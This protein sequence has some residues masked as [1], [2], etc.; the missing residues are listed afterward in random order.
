[1]LWSV[2]SISNEILVIQGFTT[3][4]WCLM[5]KKQGPWGRFCSQILPWKLAACTSV[6]LS[7][8][9]VAVQLIWTLNLRTLFKLVYRLL[10]NSAEKEADSSSSH[11]ERGCQAAEVAETTSIQKL[12][13]SN[14]ITARPRAETA[15]FAAL[16]L[17]TVPSGY[18]DRATSPHLSHKDPSTARMLL[19]EGRGSRATQPQQ[20]GYHYLRLSLDRNLQDFSRISSGFHMAYRTTHLHT[21][22]W[23]CQVFKTTTAPNNPLLFATASLA[24]PQ[25]RRK[26]GRGLSQA[27]ESHWGKCWQQFSEPIYAISHQFVFLQQQSWAA[28]GWDEGRRTAVIEGKWKGV[29]EQVWEQ[30]C[31]WISSHKGDKLQPST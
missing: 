28:S 15:A 26:K 4:F 6:R 21:P 10:R 13:P 25:S 24:S 27:G 22:G 16:A 8:R 7:P 29:G 31:R 1:M 23:T 2:F 19:G 11:L 20:L 14:L 18:N 5:T 9:G 30:L 17:V 12:P 3:S